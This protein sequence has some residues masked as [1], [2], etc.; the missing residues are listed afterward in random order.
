LSDKLYD[1]KDHTVYSVYTGYEKIYGNNRGGVIGGSIGTFLTTDTLV[2]LEGSY[3]S[4]GVVVRGSVGTF[5]NNDTLVA[6]EGS[7]S[8]D[9]YDITYGVSKS[10][11]EGERFVFGGGATIQY[12]NF[13]YDTPVTT[14]KNETVLVEDEKGNTTEQT[15]VVPVTTVENKEYDDYLVGLHLGATDKATG[16]HVGVSV[17]KGVQNDLSKATVSARLPIKQWNKNLVSLSVQYER[18]IISNS[19]IDGVDT[20]KAG[21]HYSF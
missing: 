20:V 13:K 6:L 3:S 16:L 9:S 5:L 10:I 8:K 12:V 21:I 17:A 18:T 2:A 4:D 7:Y 15:T 11:Q 14:Y 19:E 1:L